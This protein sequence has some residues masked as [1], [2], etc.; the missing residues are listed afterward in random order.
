MLHFHLERIHGI[1]RPD[2]KKKL[3]LQAEETIETS[4]SAIVVATISIRIPR[5]GSS[6]TI[7]KIFK[8]LRGPERNH[9]E[10]PTNG[11]AS[12]ATRASPFEA[13]EEAGVLGAGELQ[14]LPRPLYSS[15]R[16]CLS[17]YDR[18]FIDS[19]TFRY[20]NLMSEEHGLFS[21]SC[22]CGRVNKT[23]IHERYFWVQRILRSLPG[24]LVTSLFPR[25][26]SCR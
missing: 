14:A 1:G 11:V 12:V 5:N 16:V 4:R 17:V 22:S 23:W 6:S 2:S 10:G 21:S 9:G 8:K 15:V 13:V 3:R 25:A 20:S 19:G 26:P 7:W 18:V 24:L